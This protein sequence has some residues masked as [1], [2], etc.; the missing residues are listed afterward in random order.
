MAKKKQISEMVK[1]AI[2]S[3]LAGDIS[4]MLPEL[5]RVM[6]DECV[7]TVNDRQFE[8]EADGERFLVTI[9]KPRNQSP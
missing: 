9:S 2:T 7:Y 5:D 1:I 3:L 6:F 4:E 8:V